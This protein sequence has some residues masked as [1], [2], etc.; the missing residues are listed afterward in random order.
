MLHKESI[1]QTIFDMPGGAKVHV[2]YVEY[3]GGGEC[4]EFRI[5]NSKGEPIHRSD[6]GYGNVES[7]A[8]DAMIWFAGWGHGVSLAFIGGDMQTV[9][10]Q[11]AMIYR[12]IAH[13]FGLPVLRRHIFEA[14]FKAGLES[15]K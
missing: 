14:G 13:A 3:T 4:H 2:V 10:N 12:H 5:D 9:H 8:T 15:L 11:T 1:V 7:A 6:N